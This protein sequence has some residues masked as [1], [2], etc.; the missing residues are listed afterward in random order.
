MG[1]F[2]D[3]NNNN[4]EDESEEE[5]QSQASGQSEASGGKKKK[6]RTKTGLLKNP[7]QA[8]D[9]MMKNIE[10]FQRALEKKQNNQFELVNQ[11]FNA[12]EAKAFS[13]IDKLLAG[14]QAIVKKLQTLLDDAALRTNNTP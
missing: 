1:D 6:T 8:C 2:V 13:S 11:N 4:E 12:F 5:G 9:L 7:V 3:H 14:Q 10:L